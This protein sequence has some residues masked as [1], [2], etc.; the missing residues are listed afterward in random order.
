MLSLPKHLCEVVL[1]LGHHAIECIGKP[2][3]WRQEWTKY[4]FGT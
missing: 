4:T 1:R 3:E 2:E